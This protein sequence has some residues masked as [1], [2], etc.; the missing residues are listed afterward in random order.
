MVP[1]SSARRRNARAARETS[2]SSG[3][4]RRWRAIS[5]R[6]M[7]VSRKTMRMQS[8]CASR[9]HC[10]NRSYSELGE[11]GAGYSAASSSCRAWACKSGSSAGSWP[12]GGTIGMSF[13]YRPWRRLL[14]E[15]FCLPM[16]VTGP[17]D[18]APLIREAS[19]CRAVLIFGSIMH[20]GFGAVAGGG[21]D[22]VCFVGVKN[23][24]RL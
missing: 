5:S 9:A 10:N 14:R 20:E 1:V 21:G 11:F 6:M 8:R 16:L 19:R 4:M 2:D 17:R 15:D 12:E 3:G 24:Q 18:L 13:A 22:F 7:R 23:L